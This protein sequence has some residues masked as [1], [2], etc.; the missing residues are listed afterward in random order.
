LGTGFSE[1][2]FSAERKSNCPSRPPANYSGFS[3]PRPRS[4]PAM[5]PLTR[6]HWIATSSA[7]AAIVPLP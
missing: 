1:A 6:R 5:P 7:A 4:L 2:G 3:A